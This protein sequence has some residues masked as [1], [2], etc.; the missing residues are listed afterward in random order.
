M[1]AA[2]KTL[3]TTT[4]SG[5]HIATLNQDVVCVRQVLPRVPSLPQITGV[6]PLQLCFARGTSQYSVPHTSQVRLHSTPSQ[7]TPLDTCTSYTVHAWACFGL[8][9]FDGRRSSSQRHLSSLPETGNLCLLH[10]VRTIDRRVST[11]RT[12]SDPI[13]PIVPSNYRHAREA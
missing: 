5:H 4:P 12:R 10:S 8:R 2:D 1:P 6:E 3:Q 11:P 13:L 9:E 7:R